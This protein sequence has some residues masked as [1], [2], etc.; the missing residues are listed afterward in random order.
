LNGT[1]PQKKPQH[2]LWQTQPPKQRAQHINTKSPRSG[3]FFLSQT[4]DCI[5]LSYSKVFY[6]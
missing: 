2:R 3:G 1:K 5:L 6:F 4:P